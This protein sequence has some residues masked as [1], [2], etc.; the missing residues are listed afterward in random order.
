MQ[1][2]AALNG[3]KQSAVKKKASGGTGLMRKSIN[4]SSVAQPNQF[5]T[6]VNVSNV[7]NQSANYG[8]QNAYDFLS[9]ASLGINSNK[10][11]RKPKGGN[12]VIDSRC[13]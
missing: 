8:H 12:S 4:G 3:S 6:G 7:M 9:N 13:S 10:A 2:A 11:A 5:N 1:A